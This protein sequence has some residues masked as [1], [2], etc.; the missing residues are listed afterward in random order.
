MHLNSVEFVLFFDGNCGLCN[1]SIQF[2]LNHERQAKLKFS[3]LDSSF[4][5]SVFQELNLKSDINESILF[6]RNGK[7]YQKSTAVLHL[8]P[9]LNWYVR[10]FCVF[11]I[12]PRF[13]RDLIYDFI[14]RHRQKTFPKFCLK[15]N[16]FSDRFLE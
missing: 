11:W 16:V 10:G 3:S 6:Y 14:A 8:I 1:R 5:K 15:T 4:A 2:I 13:L 7:F 9:L 12:V